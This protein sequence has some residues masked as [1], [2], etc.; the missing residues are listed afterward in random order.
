ME[1]PNIRQ[2]RSLSPLNKSHINDSCFD[3]MD[4]SSS[5]VKNVQ[6]AAVFN[7]VKEPQ[8]P[9]EPVHLHPRDWLKRLLHSGGVFRILKKMSLP[10]Q[11]S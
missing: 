8:K 6:N 7:Q 2:N 5:N 10:S 1:I 4:L 11:V 9:Q 3:E